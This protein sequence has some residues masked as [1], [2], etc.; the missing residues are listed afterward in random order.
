MSGLFHA[1]NMHYFPVAKDVF[2]LGLCPDIKG[3]AL[4]LYVYICYL[5]QEQTKANIYVTNE[6][7]MRILGMNKDTV[8][9]ARA[10]LE[11]AGFIKFTK[12]NTGYTYS[13]VNPR[14]GKVLVKPQ[15]GDYEPLDFNLLN[16]SQLKSYYTHHVQG[17]MAETENGLTVRCPFH[18]DSSPSMQITLTDGSVWVCHSCGIGGRLIEFEQRLAKAKGESITSKEAHNRIRGVLVSTG[19]I[20]SS[21]GLPEAT[22]VYHSFDG[23]PVYE[24]LRYPGKKFK[25][26]TPKAG[27]G[28]SGPGESR[29]LRRCCMDCEKWQ[30]QIM[31]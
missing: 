2:T 19:A 18:D 28:T 12:G 1:N 3:S 13:L 30:Q 25:M 26:R 31:S 8:L 10:K 14:T 27:G 9:N 22:Y 6:Q 20:E 5:S 29:S 21:M 7:L 16:S 15:K 23:K 24:V 4:T 17:T 11:E